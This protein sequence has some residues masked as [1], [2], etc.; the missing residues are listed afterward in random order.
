MLS[1]QALSGRG[2]VLARWRWSAPRCR[3]AYSRRSRGSNHSC[4]GE[5]V[6]ASRVVNDWAVGSLRPRTLAVGRPKAMLLSRSQKAVEAGVVE[7][8]PRKAEHHGVVAAVGLRPVVG[9]PGE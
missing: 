2:P 9:R 5:G 1:A 3:Q 6:A 8:C 7:D 4:M